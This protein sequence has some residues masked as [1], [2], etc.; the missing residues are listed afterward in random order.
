MNNLI[1][2]DWFINKA[3]SKVSSIRW[4]K[5]TDHAGEGHEESS[6]G[7]LVVLLSWLMGPQPTGELRRAAEV[8]GH[9]VVSGVKDESD[10]LHKH[11][12]YDKNRTKAG[13]W[14]NG[15]G[16]GWCWPADLSHSRADGRMGCRWI[17]GNSTSRIPTQTSGL[18]NVVLDW[19]FAAQHSC[20]FRGL[21]LCSQSPA[22]KKP[23]KNKKTFL[24]IKV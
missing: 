8:R 17:S 6:W 16:G 24:L 1:H 18:R 12:D 9:V 23:K 13:C 3:Q 20:L 19:N 14:I 5:M 22:K 2:Q 4:E 7:S 11:S 15:V 10:R 21:F